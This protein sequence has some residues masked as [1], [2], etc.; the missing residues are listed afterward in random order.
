MRQRLL[1][2]CFIFLLCWDFYKEIVLLKKGAQQQNVKRWR[3]AFV[4]ISYPC[5]DSRPN[6][7]ARLL[8]LV[9]R[10][11]GIRCGFGCNSTSLFWVAMTA[12]VALRLSSLVGV[13]VCYL[14]TTKRRL[15]STF[16]IV[17]L[18]SSDNSSLV[19]RLA[20]VTEKRL[21]SFVVRALDTMD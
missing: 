21:R 13:T 9:L 5:F 20:M 14:E 7:R 8:G 10:L 18:Y 11:A 17:W 12:M 4:A 2:G 3:F 1:N 6:L 15:G 19:V 16:E